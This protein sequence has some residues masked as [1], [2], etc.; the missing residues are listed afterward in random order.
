MSSKY[1]NDARF[2]R[3]NKGSNIL[4]LQLK[5]QN[6]RIESKNFSQH[7]KFKEK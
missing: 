2:S 1:Q 7:P 5:G 3:K 4:L 6:K